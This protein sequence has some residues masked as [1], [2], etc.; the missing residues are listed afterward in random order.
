MDNIAATDVKI[1]N[2]MNFLHKC[3][4]LSTGSFTVFWFLRY[5]TSAYPSGFELKASRPPGCNGGV[6]NNINNNNNNNG[7][8]N[9]NGNNNSNDDGR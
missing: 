8:G 1:F 7:N 3:V 9:N 2:T 6:N 5:K 4:D